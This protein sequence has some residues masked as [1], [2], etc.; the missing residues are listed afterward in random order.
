MSYIH[1]WVK[2]PKFCRWE[3]VEIK[4]KDIFSGKRGLRKTKKKKKKI[5]NPC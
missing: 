5:H 1:I 2:K 3:F 4:R